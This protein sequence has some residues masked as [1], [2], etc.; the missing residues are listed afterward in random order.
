MTSTNINIK[1]RNH[2]PSIK[3]P[4]VASQ[5]ERLGTTNRSCSEVIS[6]C[7]PATIDHCQ[8]CMKGCGSTAFLSLIAGAQGPGCKLCLDGGIQYCDPQTED[9]CDLPV[10]TSSGNWTPLKGSDWRNMPRGRLKYGCT[11]A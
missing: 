3:L 4:H 1:L 10:D 5:N 7:T 11:K 8:D 2:P 9:N 6:S